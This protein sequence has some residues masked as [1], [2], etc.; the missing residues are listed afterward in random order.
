MGKNKRL[1][2]VRGGGQGDPACSFSF[3]HAEGTGRWQPR[4][5]GEKGNAQDSN[6]EGHTR[7][8]E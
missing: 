2:Q 1:L 6:Q 3:S 7:H 5:S 8:G 4:Q